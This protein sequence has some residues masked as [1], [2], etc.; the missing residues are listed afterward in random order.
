MNG[1]LSLGK[2]AS[3]GQ[4]KPKNLSAVNLSFSQSVCCRLATKVLCYTDIASCD[5]PHLIDFHGKGA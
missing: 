1:R 2:S 4:F 5:V 3:V